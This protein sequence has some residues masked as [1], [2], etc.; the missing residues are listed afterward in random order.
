MELHHAPRPAFQ[1]HQAP[2]QPRAQG[3]GA[4]DHQF[5][6]RQEKNDL[7]ISLVPAAPGTGGTCARVGLR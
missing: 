5:L 1:G 3:L 4:M 7:N 6:H 2:R